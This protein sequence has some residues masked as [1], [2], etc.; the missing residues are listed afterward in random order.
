MR[1][2]AIDKCSFRNLLLTRV[3]VREIRK[4]DRQ[5]QR[6]MECAIRGTA[7]LSFFFQIK[8]PETGWTRGNAPTRSQTVPTCPVLPTYN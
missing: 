4:I 7:L 5:S 6:Q 3:H 1:T 8:F 2:P